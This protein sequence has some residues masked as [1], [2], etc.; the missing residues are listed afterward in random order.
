[1]RLRFRVRAAE[2]RAPPPKHRAWQG[3]GGDCLQR[4]LGGRN[5]S[6][7]ERCAQQLFDCLG[8]AEWS[9]TWSID[10]V[11]GHLSGRRG[12]HVW[13]PAM[14]DTCAKATNSCC[15]SD[16]PGATSINVGPQHFF[17]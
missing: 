17:Y 11:V 7:A 10:D 5:T 8:T 6:A 9:I 3:V 16:E 14:D 13:C 12:E 4:V 2:G 1:M 15:C